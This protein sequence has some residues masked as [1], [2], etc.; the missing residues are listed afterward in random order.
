MQCG[1]KFATTRLATKMQQSLGA[2]QV[3]F[4]IFNFWIFLLF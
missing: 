2:F 1:D 4:L 3:N